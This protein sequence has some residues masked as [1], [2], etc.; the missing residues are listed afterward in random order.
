M[1]TPLTTGGLPLTNAMFGGGSLGKNTFRGQYHTLWDFSLQ[2]IIPIHENWKV[3]HAGLEPG[4]AGLVRADLRDDRWAADCGG[5]RAGYL[6]NLKAGI[7]ISFA[8]TRRGS[9]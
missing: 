6:L 8:A 5:G 7:L 4:H 3:Q 9:A 2:K 1:V